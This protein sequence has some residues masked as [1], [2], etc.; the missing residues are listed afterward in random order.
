MLIDLI[1]LLKKYNIIINGILHVGASVC[2]ELNIYKKCNLTN[3]DI[4][5]VEGN[6]ENITVVKNTLDPDIKIYNYLID[7][8]DDREVKFNISNA[9]MS[10]S[11]LEFGTHLNHHKGITMVDVKYKKTTRLDTFI[12]NNQIPIEKLNFLNVDIQG[13]ELRA[14][15]SLGNYLKNIDFIMTEINTEYVY[16]NCTLINELDSFLKENGFIRVEQKIYGNCGWG[17]AFYIRTQILDDNKEYYTS[18]EFKQY[19]T[20]KNGENIYFTC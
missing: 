18:N 10:S 13:T 7:D 14:I 4:Y 19:K 20:V 6:E 2:E 1:S 17:D 12:D 8:V 11:L 5:W 15:K 16:K 3:N 9:L